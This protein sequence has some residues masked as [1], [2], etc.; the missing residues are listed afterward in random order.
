MSNA[1]YSSRTLRFPDTSTLGKFMSEL[2][3]ATPLYIFLTGI[4]AALRAQPQR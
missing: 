2:W 1:T 4:K 3:A